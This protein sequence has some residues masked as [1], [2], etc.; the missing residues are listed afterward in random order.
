MKTFLRIVAVL[1]ALGFLFHLADLFDVRLKFTDMNGIWK[2]WVIYLFAFDF[3]AAIGLWRFKPW[4][5][6][7]FL[8]VSISQLIAYLFFQNI[9]GP[10]W[11]LVAFHLATLSTFI[12]WGSHKKIKSIEALE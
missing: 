7:A 2:I 4:G 5:I 3:I 11:S 8:L 10:Q 1:Y 12:F 9:F 6:A